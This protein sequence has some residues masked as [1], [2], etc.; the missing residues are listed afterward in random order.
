MSKDSKK[1][2]LTEKSFTIPEMNFHPEILLDSKIR[3]INNL[4][5]P[6]NSRLIIAGPKASGKTAHLYQFVQSNKDCCFSYFISDDFWNIRQS[7]F[8]TSLCNQMAE[9]LDIDSFSTQDLSEILLID[10]EKQKTIFEKF[11]QRIIEKV[12]KE[13]KICYFVIDGLEKA[14]NGN[15]GE[16]II[17][18][19]PLPNLN[20]GLYFLGSINTNSLNA[21]TFSYQKIDPHCFS[22]TETCKYLEE[23]NLTDEKLKQIQEYSGG[24]PGYLSLTKTLL[25]SGQ[26]SLELLLNE[27]SKL[28]AL[29][30][31][32]WKNIIG[33]T[34]EDEKLIFAILAFSLTPLD[35]KTIS[36][37]TNIENHLVE[38]FILNT[39]I[40]KIVN[41]TYYSF[42]PDIYKQIS[43]EKLKNYKIEVISKLVQYYSN[44]IENKESKIL[45]PEYLR[46]NK[47]FEEL[48]KLYTPKYLL[49]ISVENN[50]LS[51]V[52]K[53][54]SDAMDLAYESRDH[55]IFKY[56]VATSQ[57]N[58][59]D[60]DLIGFSEVKAL[61]SLKKYDEAMQLAYTSNIL[62]TKIRLLSQIYL[63]MEKEGITISRSNL[64]EIT[65]LVNSLDTNK[66]YPDNILNIATDLFLL[67][68]DLAAELLDKANLKDSNKSP[69]ELVAL[70]ASVKTEEPDN[71][72]VV[73]KIKS[74]ELHDFALLNSPWLSK[75][76]ALEII[77]KAKE[78][79]NI[80][81][82]EYL[83]RHWCIQN[84]SDKNVHLVIEEALNLILSDSNYN[85]TLRNLRQLSDPL[86]NC[87]LAARKLL[88]KR[89]ENFLLSCPTSPLQERTRIELNL[90]E[91][92][93]EFSP[94]ESLEKL[95]NIYHQL[96][97]SIVDVDIYCYCL[98][99][100]LITYNKLNIN[101]NLDF[102]TTVKN[103]LSDGFLNLL[104]AS[105][106]Q[107]NVTKNIIRSVAKVDFNLALAFAEML[108]TVIRRDLGIQEVLTSYIRLDNNHIDTNQIKLAI[109][110]ITDTR[111][112]ENTLIKLVLILNELDSFSN[113][114]LLNFFIDYIETI[115]DPVH[116]CKFIAYLLANSESNPQQNNELMCKNLVDSL[117]KIDVLWMR[118]ECGYDLISIV[119][120]SSPE[121]A[122]EIYQRTKSIK[123]TSTLS[124]ESI[125]VIYF[126]T[127]KLAGRL[128][129]DLDLNIGDSRNLWNLLL[130]AI[131]ILPALQ[132]K[133][134]LFSQ[135][136]ISRL[137]SGDKK[138]FDELINNKILPGINLL[139]L[140]DVFYSIISDIALAIFEFSPEEAKNWVEKLPYII[141]NVTWLKISY[142]LITQSNIND[143]LDDQPSSSCFD[144]QI[145][146]KILKL[147]EYATR[148]QEVYLICRLMCQS[149]SSESC[150]LPEGKK[151]DILTKIEDIIQNKLPDTLN[152]YHEGYFILANGQIERAKRLSAKKTKNQLPK[153]Y[154][155]ISNQAKKIENIADRVLVLS[156][157]AVIFKEINPTLA[158][159]LLD[160]AYKSICS[161]TNIKDRIS[162]LEQ[163]ADS[164][165]KLKNSSMVLEAYK[166][167]KS[168]AQSMDG[169]E[170]DQ[171]ISS[172][173]QSAYQIDKDLAN[174]LSE[175]IDNQ[176]A[177]YKLEITNNSYD[178]SKSPHR[179]KLVEN[180]FLDDEIISAASTKMLK[181]LTSG[182]AVSCSDETIFKWL[183]LT[184]KMSFNKSKNVLNWAI[185][186]LIRQAAES[187]KNDLAYKIISHLILN[188][189]L[190]DLLGK[191]FSHFSTIPD[192]LIDNFQGL[193]TNK[194]LFKE[195]QRQQAI[196]FL[197]SW[198][199]H[200]SSEFIKICDPYFYPDQLWLL[201]II[202]S[203]IQVQILTSL[204]VYDKKNKNNSLTINDEKELIKSIRSELRSKYNNAW[205]E[206][207]SQNPPSTLVVVHG[208]IFANMDVDKFHDRYIITDKGGL[209]LGTSLN[210]FGKK[211]FFITV[212]STEDSNYVSETYIDPKL[213]IN[214]F[215]SKVVYFEL[216]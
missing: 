40:I 31:V 35:I 50:S 189:Q 116:K 202:P 102:I 49:D 139:P 204:E 26:L 206:I 5:S 93:N 156:E 144:L 179:I 126:E 9:Y 128:V 195:G 163:I 151:L 114:K 160:E 100:I 11:S 103:Q 43:Q 120:K 184:K 46:I 68:P 14:F 133:L 122:D 80:K 34:N 135:F 113:P 82:S 142:R 64:D 141:Q 63:S 96:I 101:D 77:R 76:P 69:I 161:V 201:K 3:E 121:F 183:L 33:S 57:I 181:S 194:K 73:D 99:R 191:N 47:N 13:R 193:S 42:F 125:G 164:Y 88:I 90:I 36:Q 186:T 199:K 150:K 130:K 92:L 105:A 48:D 41:E 152:I 214:E 71:E 84:K 16:R 38:K 131:E 8:L 173:I 140:S 104:G 192:N 182:K 81:S 127:L 78:A 86:I 176:L 177:N 70:L 52:K 106:D 215:F 154:N 7:A 124:N 79:N 83:L 138:T 159:E 200:N 108:N 129:G 207:S 212:L 22:Y 98:S 55:S 146:N 115:I 168:Y 147:L 20:R 175:K 12:T 211:E 67:L 174:L 85:I 59:L 44:N 32:Q 111:V 110:K 165:S 61:I 17:D 53:L 62:S 25:Q 94:Q 23:L 197:S 149:I 66:I 21:I 74:N 4:F 97:E 216:Q 210:G 91:A 157:L 60:H 1:V 30:D 51:I 10:I 172:L 136:A 205:L 19:F 180:Q 171:I 117:E 208:S 15:P 95:E 118:V 178:L 107:L 134:F 24:L 39:N 132:I 2:D 56:S 203:D 169:I 187:E 37:I 123:H 54:L 29:F 185:E 65:F 137:K 119:S 109:S 188:C 45:L 87:Q 167:A 27:P 198:I 190:I 166:L 72:S 6:E 209:S 148:D 213:Q 18:L 196:E 28:E 75:L 170:K 143:L 58:D 145:A 155:N 112:K 89:F 162:R 158:R 153:K